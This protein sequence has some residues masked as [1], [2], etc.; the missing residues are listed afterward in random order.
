MLMTPHVISNEGD[1]R[2]LTAT[3]EQQFR[4]VLD[5]RTLA[6]PREPTR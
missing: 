6:G 3:I 1:S 4:N 2:S 5:T